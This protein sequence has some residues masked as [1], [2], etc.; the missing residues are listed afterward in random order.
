[1]VSTRGPEYPLVD[2]DTHVRDCQDWSQPR[3]RHLQLKV[4]VITVPQFRL[5]VGDAIELVEILQFL[6]DWLNSDPERLN[7]S[8]TRFVGVRAYDI[9]DLRADLDRIIFMLGGS[10]GETL[11]G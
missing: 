11:F 10:D 7:A 5:D 8:L 6:S 9:D 1:L 4:E 3:Y 2:H